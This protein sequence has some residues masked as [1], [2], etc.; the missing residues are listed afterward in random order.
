MAL[1]RLRESRA[2]IAA[3]DA[4]IAKARLAIVD[5]QNVLDDARDFNN[6]EQDAQDAINCGDGFACQ[7]RERPGGYCY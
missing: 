7:R 2:F 4:G 3:R 5:L 1:R 6:I